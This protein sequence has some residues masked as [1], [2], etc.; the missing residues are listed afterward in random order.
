MTTEQFLNKLDPACRINK[1]ADEAFR[2]FPRKVSIHP[3]S[4][5]S[6]PYLG[7]LAKWHYS[8]KVL[9]SQGKDNEAL[10]Y[11]HMPYCQAQCTY[12]GFFGGLYSETKGEEY[13]NAL[14]AEMAAEHK[15]MQHKKPLKAIY[16]GGGTPTALAPRQFKRLLQAIKQYFTIADD[17]E[18]TVE[19][20]N[21]DLSPELIEACLAEGVNRFSLGVQ[22]FNTKIR[23]SIG[24]FSDEKK[25]IKELELLASYKKATVVI[26][27]IYGLP[28]QTLSHWA[29][30]LDILKTLPL[31][32]FDLYQMNLIPTSNLFKQVQQ[33]QIVLPQVDQ[34]YKMFEHALTF[35]E[36]NNFKRLS[37]S[38]WCKTDKERNIY[39]R[40]QKSKNDSYAYGSGAG[41]T[42]NGIF[43][44]NTRSPEA[45]LKTVS[46]GKKPVLMTMKSPQNAAAVSALLNQLELL[47]INFK[48]LNEKTGKED[49]KKSLSGV[50]DYLQH[51]NLIT[52]TKE[53]FKLSKEGQFW[54]VNV[55]QIMINAFKALA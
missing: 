46:S 11:V 55:S 32:G 54:Q 42:Y 29:Y 12:C 28:G 17:A 51:G 22:T 18:I 50:I 34:R 23:R 21:S 49:I 10:L 53:G 33:G 24:R 13:V 8:K 40:L 3:F 4:G 47:E 16:F 14:L 26:D 36:E 37:V 39:N 15:L 5:G 1:E 27:L 41:G 38:H 20:R 31:D 2:I 44:A 7:P 19:G 9:S 43:Y 25:V 45:Y 6:K 52:P 35:T 48:E 30:D